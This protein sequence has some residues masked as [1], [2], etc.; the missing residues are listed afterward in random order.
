[1]LHITPKMELVGMPPDITN[2]IITTI[3]VHSLFN[4]LSSC[5][6]FNNNK[7]SILTFQ[8]KYMLALINLPLKNIYVIGISTQ[9]NICNIYCKLK[10]YIYDNPPKIITQTSRTYNNTTQIYNID[11]YVIPSYFM[12]NI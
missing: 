11:A 2:N 8:I 1:M 7:H 5:T 10:N 12:S 3:P 4:L 9:D 6:H